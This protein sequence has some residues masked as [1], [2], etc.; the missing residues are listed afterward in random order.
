M[1][2]VLLIVPQV[3]IDRFVRVARWQSNKPPAGGLNVLRVLIY[4]AS[5]TGLVIGGSLVYAN[6]NPSFRYRADEYIPGFAQLADFAADKWVDIIDTIKP[7]PTEKVGL[8]DFGSKFD[9]KLSTAKQNV[10]EK[11]SLSVEHAGTKEDKLRSEEVLF[12]ESELPPSLSAEKSTKPVPED[13]SGL[14]DTDCSVQVS[15]QQMNKRKEAKESVVFDR[16][17][18]EA[19][20]EVVTEV[21][22][23]CTY[24]ANQVI[25]HFPIACIFFL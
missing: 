15:T 22:S 9:S 4:G 20:P 18:G 25:K 12:K 16:A 1:P 3:N 19:Q 14:A 23:S 5:T 13:V 7:K 8:K 10:A 2:L 17:V 24:L 21:V 11:D 6:Y